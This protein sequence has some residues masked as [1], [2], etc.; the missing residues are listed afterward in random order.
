MSLFKIMAL[1]LLVSC[2]S[3]SSLTLAPS[4]MLPLEDFDTVTMGEMHRVPFKLGEFNDK[5]ADPNVVGMAKTGLSNITTP[6]HIDG[7][8][9]V[10][11]KERLESGL[12]K[13][14]LLISG[15]SEA[16]LS[17][18]ILDMWVDEVV[19]TKHTG[20]E[21]SQCRMKVALEFSP[22]DDAQSGR[23]SG[24]VEVVAASKS[25]FLD[26]T[27]VNGPMLE[28]CMNELL[29]K[30]MREEKFQKV[31]GFKLKSK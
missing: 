21:R 11:L 4:K 24:V 5:R 27:D 3:Y 10:Y 1:S 2:A 7:G 12:R 13:R 15:A 16:T 25:T 23:W 6:V 18:S 30:L 14:G 20:T 17:G 29:E 8:S 28:S 22:K 26:T 31:A 9:V 19:D